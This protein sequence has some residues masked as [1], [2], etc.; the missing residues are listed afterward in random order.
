[1]PTTW[2]AQTIF[3]KAKRPLAVPYSRGNDSKRIFKTEE[4]LPRKLPS[5]VIAAAPP[6]GVGAVA[7]PTKLQLPGWGGETKLRAAA[8]SKRGQRPGAQCHCSRA[9]NCSAHA[10]MRH[11]DVAKQTSRHDAK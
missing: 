1:M 4:E 6:A 11:Q 7:E 10:H 5:P 9:A 8:P 3:V 2:P